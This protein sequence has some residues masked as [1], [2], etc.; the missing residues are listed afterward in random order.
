[1]CGACFSTQLPPNSRH[2]HA[3]ALS[4]ETHPAAASPDPNSAAV[5]RTLHKSFSMDMQHNIRHSPGQLMQLPKNQ[6]A[7]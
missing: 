2:R 6:A 1:M 4:L 5:C 3:R 7:Y